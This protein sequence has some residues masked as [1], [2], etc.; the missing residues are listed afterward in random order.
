MM[1]TVIPVLRY[2]DASAEP[3]KCNPRLSRWRMPVLLTRA[4][5]MAGPRTQDS[6]G[7]PLQQ[8]VDNMT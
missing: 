6:V 1:S 4:P 5:R 8:S 3:A 2:R 7:L